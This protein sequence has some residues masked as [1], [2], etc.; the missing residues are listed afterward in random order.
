MPAYT[1]PAAGLVVT[2]TRDGVEIDRG[3]AGDGVG[4][5][6]VAMRLLARQSDLCAGDALSVDDAEGDMPAVS[7]ASHYSD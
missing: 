1:R 2:L 6:L 7:R 5:V 3:I 4:A